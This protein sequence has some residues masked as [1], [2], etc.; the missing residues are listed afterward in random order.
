[1]REKGGA[2][3]GAGKTNTIPG[4]GHEGC[5]EGGGAKEGEEGS[6]GTAFEGAF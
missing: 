4:Q 5:E 6:L 3:T 1:M 2:K